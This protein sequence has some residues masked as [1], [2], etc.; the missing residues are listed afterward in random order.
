MKQ[1][2][3]VVMCLLCV[4][5]LI[6]CSTEL[7]PKKCAYCGGEI[8]WQK[9]NDGGISTRWRQQSK[10]VDGKDYHYWCYKIAKEK[11]EIKE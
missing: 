2:K 5:F 6:G 10:E 3:V 7:S 8:Y 9:L 11:G 1:K 4:I